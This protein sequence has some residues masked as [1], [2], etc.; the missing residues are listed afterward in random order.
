[1]TVRPTR[2]LRLTAQSVNFRLRGNQPV[3]FLHVG[4]CAGT[5]LKEALK[6]DPPPAPMRLL[7]HSHGVRMMDLPRGDAFFFIVRDPVDRFVSGFMARRNRD[8]GRYREPWSP[9]ETRAF[10]RFPTPGAVGIALGAGGARRDEAV[11]ALRSIAH[12]RS[13]YWDWFGNERAVRQ[14]ASKILWIGFQEELGEHIP[15]LARRLGSAEIRLPSDPKRANR[16]EEHVEISSEA[17]DALA[18]WYRRDYD[19]VALCRDLATSVD[20]RG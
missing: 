10:E 7:M 16:S 5:A 11:E 3:H 4:K 8:T 17:R 18:A 9:A 15:Q 14:R 6:N 12:V 1:M 13:S 19:F 20:A 2:Y